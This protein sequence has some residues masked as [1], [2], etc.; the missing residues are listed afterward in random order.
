MLYYNSQPGDNKIDNEWLN[1]SNENGEGEKTEW[2]EEVSIV[3]WM[4]EFYKDCEVG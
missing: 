3:K 2:K 4:V 1:S